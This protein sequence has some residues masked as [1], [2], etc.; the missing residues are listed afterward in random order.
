MDSLLTA[1]LLFIAAIVALMTYLV[2]PYVPAVALGAAAAIALAIGVWWH[3]SQ[4]SIDYRTSTWQEQLRNYA[5]YVILLL[6]ILLSYAFYVFGWG[7]I[8]GYVA[9]AKTAVVTASRRAT[10]QLSSGLSRASSAAA[11]I[12]EAA[13]APM[14]S[15]TGANFF[16]SGRR[17][18]SIPPLE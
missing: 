1:F 15:S 13:V 4:F 18:M 10:T 11:A 5:S 8:S 6:V 7:G 12:G 3:W 17:N 16:N 14:N 2:I 9:Q